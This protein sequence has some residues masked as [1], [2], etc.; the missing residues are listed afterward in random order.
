MS[1]VKAEEY[2]P[3]DRELTVFSMLETRDIPQSAQYEGEL[4]YICLSEAYQVVNWMSINMVNS[5]HS[6]IIKACM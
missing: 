5:K 4:R 6:I 1:D 2:L 3:C